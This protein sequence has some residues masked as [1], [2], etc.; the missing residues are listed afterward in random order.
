M[1]VA[2]E[3]GAVGFI[4]LYPT[5]IAHPNGDLIPNFLVTMI[6]E[7][8]YDKVLASESTTATCA[9]LQKQLKE[10]KQPLSRQLD[11]VIDLSVK[12]R[13]FPKAECH[14]VVAW[15]IGSDPI[16]KDEC[17]VI[18]GHLDACGDHIGLRFPGAEDNASGCAV[19]MEI[20]KAFV[21]NGV[22]PKRSVVFV[23]FG[24][25]EQGG[26]GSA[27]F[28]AHLPTQFKKMSAFINFDMVG[29]GTKVNIGMSELME[30]YKNLLESSDQGLSISNV[31]MIRA[32][33]VRSGD[34][35]PFFKKSV[36]LVSLSSNGPRPE[37]LYHQPGDLPSLVQPEIMEKI[38][39]LMFRFA[40]GLC[41]D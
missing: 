9:V 15:L 40:F 41:G 7:S 4:Y 23:L 25:E 5:V 3:K 14:N 35:V 1:K 34:I 29:M 10:T 31:R 13:Y 22:P 28:A 32:I 38:S 36:P 26:H 20:A 6:S 37:N 16:L 11:A 27:Y 21:K 2:S 39:K 12:A 17:V 33:G 19:V 30:K 24:S 8:F 18:G